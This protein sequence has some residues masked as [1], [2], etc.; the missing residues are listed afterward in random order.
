VPTVWL[1]CIK[2]ANGGLFVAAFAVL[3]E[4]LQPKRFAGI[5]GGSPAVSLANLLVIALAQ[6]GSAARDAATGMI[7]GAVALAVACAAAIPA[8]RRRGSIVGSGV[9]WAVW[10]VV[11]VT[12]G[13]ALAGGAAAASGPA[14]G[15]RS[16]GQRQTPA[17][18]RGGGRLFTIDVGALREIRPA[19]LAIRF[20]FGAAVSIAAGLVGVLA[21]KT[22]GGVMLAAPAVV[23]ATLT[24]IEKREGRDAAVTE[25]QGAV[26]GA[27]ALIGFALVAAVS[28]TAIPLA[29]ALLA[30]LATWIVVAV[31][32][33]VAQSFFSP[34]WRQDVRQLAFQRRDAAFVRRG[35]G[36]G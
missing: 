9:L 22:A 34:A 30:S 5:F 1:I 27:V 24:I 2:A 16:G 17:D 25:T 13:F 20:A 12:V 6:G 26:P 32:A 21:G 29:A 35:G 8:V 36:E 33:Y 31:G 14:A 4:M 18:A 19:A 10:I 11:G 28:M 3:G 7:A 23:P 15:G